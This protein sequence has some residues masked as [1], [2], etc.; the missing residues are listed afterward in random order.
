MLCVLHGLYAQ[1]LIVVDLIF[2][3]LCICVTLLET[4]FSVVDHLWTE[5]SPI[6]PLTFGGNTEPYIDQ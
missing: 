3:N 6:C 4:V 1:T 5:D 2:V